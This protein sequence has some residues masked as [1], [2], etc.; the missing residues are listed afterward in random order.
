MIWALWAFLLGI[1]SC[2]PNISNNSS[3]SSSSSQPTLTAADRNALV[4]F[5]ELAAIA[6][7]LQGNQVAIQHGNQAAMGQALEPRAP[8]NA[9]IP[10]FMLPS[11]PRQA[12]ALQGHQGQGNR[13]SRRLFPPSPTATTQVELAAP[14]SPLEIGSPNLDWDSLSEEDGED[15]EEA[16]IE[17]DN[18]VENDD[19]TGSRKRAGSS[20]DEPFYKRPRRF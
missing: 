4:R 10:P 7:N 6:L 8:A 3:G 18:E 2:N 12:A 14:P 5:L 15:T 20:P 9:I 19:Y 11:P 13:V 1:C 16:P 17:E